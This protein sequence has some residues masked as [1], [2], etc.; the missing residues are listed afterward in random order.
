MTGKDK[1]E[2]GLMAPRVLFLEE[3]GGQPAGVKT[4]QLLAEGEQ[5]LLEADILIEE[6]GV[7]GVPEQVEITNQSVAAALKAVEPQGTTT[8][9]LDTL[10]DLGLDPDDTAEWDPLAEE[11]LRGDPEASISPDSK[12]ARVIKMDK[13]A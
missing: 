1:Q 13:I 2:W 5:Q 6:V 10:A 3:E 9:D 4:E 11:L 8:I 12:G 7:P